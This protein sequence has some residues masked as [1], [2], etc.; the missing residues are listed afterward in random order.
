VSA[1]AARALLERHGLAAHRGRGQNFLHDPELAAKLV[2]LAEVEPDETVLEVGTGLGILTRAL[3]ARAARVVTVEVDAG[4]VRAL[5]AEG[6]LPPNVVLL[7][8]DALDL[9]WEALLAERPGPARLVANLPYSAAAPMLR[10]FLD[11]AGE[12]RGW[13][14][15]VQREVAKRLDAAPGSRDYGSLSV[16]HQLVGRVEASLDLHPRCFYPVPRVTSTFLRARPRK[17]AS[18]RAGELPVVEDVV[19][20][21]FAHRRKTLVNALQQARGLEASAI[22]AVL[23]SVGLPPRVRAEEVSPDVW[24]AIARGL[25]QA[26]GHGPWRQ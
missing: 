17:D 15:M 4:L 18:L 13:S 9:D 11:V 2:R 22:T 21:G 10:R 5:H 23:R 25:V 1:A 3:A 20:G 24:I 19:R 12:L 8:A 6:G 26:G 16:L 14:V 7:H